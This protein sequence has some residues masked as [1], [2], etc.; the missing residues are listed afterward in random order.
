MT[1]QQVDPPPRRNA[2]SAGDGG[3]GGGGGGGNPYGGGRHPPVDGVHGRQ[4]AHLARPQLLPAHAAAH[5]PVR[6]DARAL[7][8]DR[9]LAAR[10]RD[11]AADGA[12]A[13]PAHAR[14]LL[15]RAHDLRPA[16]PVRLHDGDRRRGRGD[17][18]VGRA[19][20]RPAPPARVHHGVRE[21]RHGPVG[22]GDLQLLPAAR[23]VLRVVGPP[24]G[25]AAHVRDGGRHAPRTST[26][27]C[28]TTTSRRWC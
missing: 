14:R 11:P 18:H 5:A 22:A 3:G 2:V 24:P 26:S 19:R 4:R 1:L 6:H 9:D 13:Q 28:S 17:H 15:R 25:R 27:R 10:Q 20:P 12:A 7:R 21:R 23:R 8:R 16:L